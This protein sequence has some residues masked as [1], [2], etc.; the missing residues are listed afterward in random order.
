MDIPTI[1]LIVSIAALLLGGGIVWKLFVAGK[2]YGEATTKAS[3]QAAQIEKLQG[4]VRELEA[5]KAEAAGLKTKVENME[6]QH[7][8]EVTAQGNADKGQD[9]H[10]NKVERDLK[11]VEDKA[12]KRIDECVDRVG[13]AEG[14]VRVFEAGMKHI[15]GQIETLL[16]EVRNLLKTE[17]KQEIYAQRCNTLEEEVKG[18]QSQMSEMRGRVD[19]MKSTRA[20][21]ES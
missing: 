12:H 18:L 5:A 3:N 4:Q 16:G 7:Q 6:K 19:A 2:A 13:R 8:Q 17:T 14:Q 21:T 9:K 11:D 1:S 10:I 15:T 20:R